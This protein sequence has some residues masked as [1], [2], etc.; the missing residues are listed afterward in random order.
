MGL[1]DNTYVHLTYAN[2]YH[3]Y[4]K[5]ISFSRVHLIKKSLEWIT[6]IVCIDMGE[7]S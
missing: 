1:S 6:Y 3:K 2:V 7:S 5:G 4:S